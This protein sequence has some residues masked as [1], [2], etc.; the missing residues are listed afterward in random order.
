ML[1]SSFGFGPDV[2]LPG[3][4]TYPITTLGLRVRYEPTESSYIQ[5]AVYDGIPG[6]P[7]N[8]SGTQIILRRDDG[9]FIAAEAGITS[10]EEDAETDYFKLAL[11]GWYLTTDYTDF[12][13]HER[14]GQGG[15]YIIGERKIFSEE[16][17]SQ[18]LGVFGQFGIND[19]KRSTLQNYTG[20]GLHYTGLFP[21]R[22]A[23]ITTVGIAQSR[24]SSDYREA[25]EG[26]TT[27]ETSYE[28]SHR[29]SLGSGLAIQPD[30]QYV[31]RPGASR[32]VGHAL[33]VGTRLQVSF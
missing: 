27:A 26:S 19:G 12:A 33:V 31:N 18:G 3:N 24:L 15:A 16:D 28:L 7:N 30:I 14:S 13:D 11:G 25:V 23:D 5:T 4:S 20:F 8:Y 2:S 17:A 29:F 1:N 9:V 21:C 22:D 32:E 10:T 6:N